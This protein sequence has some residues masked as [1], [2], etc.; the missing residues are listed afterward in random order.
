MSLRRP[1]SFCILALGSGQ[2][3]Q[4][5]GGGHELF[6]AVALIPE[7]LNFGFAP[8]DRLTQFSMPQ[9]GEID[10]FNHGT[11]TLSLTI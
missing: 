6:K 1:R 3:H 4:L 11:H 7:F 10:Q 9:K 2:F 8:R 5:F